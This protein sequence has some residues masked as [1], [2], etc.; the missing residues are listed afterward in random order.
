[1]KYCVVF[2]VLMLL[3]VLQL[4]GGEFNLTSLLDYM[5]PPGQWWYLSAKFSAQYAYIF[6]SLQIILG[7]TM[8][9]FT[10]LHPRPILLIWH[11]TLGLLAVGSTLLHVVFFFLASNLRSG[12]FPFELLTLQFSR[13]YYAMYISIGLIATILLFLIAAIGLC[14]HI[15]PRWIFEYG[16][17]F[18]WFVWL[19]AFLHSISIGSETRDVLFWSLFYAGSA[20]IIIVLLLIRLKFLLHLWFDKKIKILNH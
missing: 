17:R 3:P 9:Q 5:L 20:G 7:M 13:G 15:L 8:A 11:K 6:L 14:R 1:M 16:H 4:L 18:A 19:L 12:H 10:M 2:M